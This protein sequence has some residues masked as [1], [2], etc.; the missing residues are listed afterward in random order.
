MT[1][2][3][4]PN[5]GGNLTPRY[6]PTSRPTF[7]CPSKQILRK[8]FH[9]TMY[10]EPTKITCITAIRV[11]WTILYAFDFHYLYLISEATTVVRF[12]VTC[13]ALGGA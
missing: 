3:T 7:S 12:T 6:D 2:A 10:L 8:R 4:V 13:M 11:S 5:L 9:A 1:I